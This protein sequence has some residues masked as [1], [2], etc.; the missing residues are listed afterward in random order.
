MLDMQYLIAKRA[1]FGPGATS[2]SLKD[3]RQIPARF[4]VRVKHAA[5]D[6]RATS[7]YAVRSP[8]GKRRSPDDERHS[9]PEDSM[10]EYLSGPR[11]QQLRMDKVHQAKPEPQDFT[12]HAEP[13]WRDIGQDRLG[14]CPDRKAD[15]ESRS[16]NR[17][18]V[19]GSRHD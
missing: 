6:S 11:R 19:L 16:G 8:E 14:G 10:R 9:Q 17:A 15:G 1:S 13:C 2:H 12:A 5:F 3:S 7:G 4:R 18:D